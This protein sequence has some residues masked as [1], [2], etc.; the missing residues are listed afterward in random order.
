MKK[1]IV[2]RSSK[3]YINPYHYVLCNLTPNLLKKWC[4]S[5]RSRKALQTP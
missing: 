1:Y 4:K 5:A 2:R 3:H